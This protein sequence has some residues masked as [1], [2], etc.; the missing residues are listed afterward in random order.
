MKPLRELMNFRP[1]TAPTKYEAEP[2]LGDILYHYYVSHDCT[3]NEATAYV[4]EYLAQLQE[5][6]NS[7][8]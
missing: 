4:E 3:P 5:Y 7:G 2:C 1:Q 8:I 6:Y